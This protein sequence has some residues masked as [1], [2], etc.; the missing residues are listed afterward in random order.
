MIA[1]FVSMSASCQFTLS[2]SDVWI[3][4]V[5]QYVSE[6]DI[7]SDHSAQQ[8]RSTMVKVTDRHNPDGG[9]CANRIRATIM[10][11]IC[12]RYEECVY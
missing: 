3:G 11:R 7:R 6:E 8:S 9:D 2:P 10:L 4:Y 12:P 1:C 5:V